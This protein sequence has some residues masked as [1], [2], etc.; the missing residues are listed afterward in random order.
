MQLPELARVLSKDLENPELL[1]PWVSPV[2]STLLDSGDISIVQ[3]ACKSAS[4]MVEYFPSED[5]GPCIMSSILQLVHEEDL[6]IKLLGLGTIN[7][8]IPHLES[9][10]NLHFIGPDIVALAYDFDPKVRSCAIQCIPTLVRNIKDLGFHVKLL[11]IFEEVAYEH[12][13][14]VKTTCAGLLGELFAV[15]DEVMQ[16]EFL[17]KITRELLAVG[18]DK[19]RKTAGKQVGAIL[20][21]SNSPFLFEFTGIYNLLCRNQNIQ[22]H[23]AFYFPGLLL[24]RGPENWPLFADS[25]FY[26]CKEGNKRTKTCIAAFIHEIGKILGPSGAFDSLFPV[27]NR[28]VSKKAP[29]RVKALENLGNFSKVLPLQKRPLLLPIIKKMHTDRTSWRVRLLLAQQMG[30]LAENYPVERLKSDL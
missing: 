27:Y 4:L 26:M 5:K 23:C 8:I 3:A 30:V 9:D 14:T 15:C 2:L 11:S 22:R 6:E 16:E 7:L 28:M 1:R 13:E 20:S 17:V 10:M 12:N 24:M 25:F 21:S 29:G 18:S 19:S